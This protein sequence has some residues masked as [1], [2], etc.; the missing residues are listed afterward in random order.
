MAK[1][2]L[3]L[4]K[5]ATLDEWKEIYDLAVKFRELRCWEWIRDTD[6][7]GVQHPKTGENAY[8]CVLGNGGDIFG[9]NAYIGERGL[10]SYMDTLYDTVPQDDI[11]YIQDC[12]ALSFEDREMLDKKDLNKIRELG[13]KFRGRNQWP[14]FRSFKPGYCPWYID[15]DELEKM[16]HVIEQVIDVVTRCKEDKSLLMTDDDSKILVRVPTRKKN[17]LVWKDKYMKVEFNEKD[18]SEYGQIDELALKRIKHSKAKKM[19]VWELDFFH[20]PALVKEGERPYY[21]LVFLAADGETGIMLDLLMTS[22]FEGYMKEFQDA[23]VQLLA[24]IKALPEAIV[25]QRKDVLMAIE[26]VTRKLGVK[27]EPV[28]ELIVIE[29]FR[30]SLEMFL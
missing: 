12:I 26:P 19:G 10:E 24:K 3:R 2:E 1:V 18:Y 22:N 13:L 5:E 4:K 15:A 29:E 6:I 11:L 7:F 17:D 28:E 25:I 27:I 9:L 30:K 16:K 23:F 14:K 20:V 8:C 21:P